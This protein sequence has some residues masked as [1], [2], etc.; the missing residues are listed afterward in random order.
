VQGDGKDALGVPYWSWEEWPGTTLPIAV[1]SKTYTVR[2]DVWSKTYKL[3]QFR[4]GFTFS[5]PF[6]RWFA[7]VSLEDQLAERFPTSIN[8]NNCT[9]RAQ[10]FNNP[11]IPHLLPW[12]TE[13]G[14]GSPSMSEVVKAAMA[15]PDYLKF[16]TMKPGVGDYQY[17]IENAH[18]KFH[19]HIGGLWLG[20]EDGQQTAPLVGKSYDYVGTMTSNQS[21]YDPIF[22]LHHSN[23]ERQLISWQR[24]WPDSKPPQDVL[25]KVLYPWT[26]PELVAK[27]Q[28]SWNTPTS[29]DSD[30]T[31]ADWFYANLSYE[32]DAYI[33]GPDIQRARR[34]YDRIQYVL[35]VQFGEV[36]KG[37][38]FTVEDDEGNL[39]ASIAV[40]N[41]IGSGC[42]KC[43]DRNTISFY[44][45]EQTDKK[46]VLKRNGLV[47]PNVT[48]SW[49]VKQ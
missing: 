29:P 36:Q 41:A 18:N 31:L 2:S 14:S 22:W 7:P 9:L 10:G 32:Y 27:G 49:S 23:V 5:N 8:D 21:I 42:I 11:N 33:P 12:L 6:Q 45:E 34:L 20:G 38:E 24:I 47:V 35:T 17:S 15:Q 28:F 3:T 39:L 4:K 13:S 44:I 43:L 40:L 1:T 30:A 37:G 26:K 16:A 48:Y 46:L 25:D 19:N